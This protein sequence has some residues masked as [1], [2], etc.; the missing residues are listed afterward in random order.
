MEEAL[1][2]VA[3]GLKQTEVKYECNKCKD[4]GF[5]ALDM[6]G[7]RKPSIDVPSSQQAGIS[8]CS[9]KIQQGIR[10]NMEYSG[11]DLE[12]YDKKTLKTFKRDTEEA[13]AMYALALKF[14]AE[15]KPQGIGYFGKSGTGKT[16]ICI[17]ICHELALRNIQHRYFNYRTDIQVLKQ[18]K[19]DFEEYSKKMNEYKTCSVLYIDDLFKLIKNNKGEID[20][21]ELQIMFEIINTRYMNNKPIIVSSEMTVNEIKDIDEAT[22]GRIYE[23]LNGI[24]MKCEA[25]NRRIKKR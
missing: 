8:I 7:N 21:Q 9:C 5:I 14:L 13:Q 24:G 3:Q 18:L 17:A 1:M 16:H 12:E 15:Y 10:T 22:G 20:Q 11:I 25:E 4:S 23:M 6:N 2:R 19:Y